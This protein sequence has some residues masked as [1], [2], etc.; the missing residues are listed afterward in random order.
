[1]HKILHGMALEDLPVEFPTRLQLVVN[2]KT[3]Q[4]LG[5]TIPPDAPD[6]GRRGDQLNGRLSSPLERDSCPVV[7]P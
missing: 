3:A 6:A 5:I 2:L 7:P 1:M 4:T